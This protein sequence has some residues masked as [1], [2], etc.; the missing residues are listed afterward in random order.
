MIDDFGNEWEE[1]NQTDLSVSELQE[2][3]SRYFGIFPF[4]E[5]KDHAVGFDMGCGSGRWAR[6]V[7][8][9]IGTLNC[10]D[11]SEKAINV[12]RNNLKNQSNINFYTASVYDQTLNSES[13]D[14]GYC[15]GVL[16]HISNTQEGIRSCARILKKG[17]PFLLYLYYNFENKPFWFRWIWRATDFFRHI[18][19]ML[20]FKGKKI[21]ASASAY[22]VYY[23]LAKISLMLDKMNVKTSNIPLASYKSM[24]LYTMKTDALDRFGTKIEKRFSQ[25]EIK[26]MLEAE[27]FA[28]IQF[29]KNTPYWVALCY[30]K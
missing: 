16:H 8:P 7:A 1:Y 22:L 10:I 6:L 21:V 27:G 9:K 3:F 14:F 20:P 13:Q 23:P 28:R 30:K 26:G 4:S 18:I 29:S 25:N 19:S 15:L 2:I 17:A 11:A 5:L 24:S 12:A